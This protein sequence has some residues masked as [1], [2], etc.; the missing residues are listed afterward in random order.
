MQPGRQALRPDAHTCS[1][2]LPMPSQNPREQF[3][4]PWSKISALQL[5]CNCNFVQKRLITGCP[6][7][8]EQAARVCRAERKH[9]V[10]STWRAALRKHPRS[11]KD[12]PHCSPVTAGISSKQGGS[13]HCCPDQPSSRSRIRALVAGAMH[14]PTK[15]A[16]APS[17]Y[18]GRGACPS[19]PHCRRPF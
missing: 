18:R 3:L 10:R 12:L 11:N 9:H 6:F 15:L 16:A 1:S 19:S 17:R 13:A 4:P 5:A 2:V 8:V 7:S 14:V